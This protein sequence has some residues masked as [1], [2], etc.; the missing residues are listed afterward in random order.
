MTLKPRVLVVEDEPDLLLVLRVNL[1]GAGFETSLAA[2]GVTALRRIDQEGFDVVVLDLMLPV[3]DGWTVLHEL[4]ERP[5]R[6]SVVVCSAKHDPRDMVRAE[7][8]GAAAYLT[9][10]F[11]PEDVVDAVRELT[12]RR[13]APRVVEPRPEIGLEDLPGIEPV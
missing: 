5:G 9:K 3:V 4:A 1:E 11:D 2:D 8:L 10:P 6:P 12:T 7:E 13:R